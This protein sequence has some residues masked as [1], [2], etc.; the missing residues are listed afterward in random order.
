[1]FTVWVE[2]SF[3]AYPL[4]IEK[5][6]RSSKVNKL[7][8]LQHAHSHSGNVIMTRHSSNVNTSEGEIMKTA[9]SSLK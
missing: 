4:H 8:L 3:K 9:H 6:K 2:C 5:R 1:M 7:S